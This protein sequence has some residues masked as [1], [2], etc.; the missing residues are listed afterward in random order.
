MNGYYD[1]LRAKMQKFWFSTYVR[2]N[3]QT[4]D[5]FAENPGTGTV[6][7]KKCHSPV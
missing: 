1:L 7:L 5:S 4:K 2:M 3:C 6:P